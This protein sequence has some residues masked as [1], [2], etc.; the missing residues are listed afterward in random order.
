MQQIEPTAAGS[1]GELPFWRQFR[2]NLIAVFIGLALVPFLA[3]EALT[4][5]QTASEAQRQVF[6]QLESVSQLKQ[7]QIRRWLNDS[8]G[9]LN[10]LAS[11]PTGAA[12]TALAADPADE[13][14]RQQANAALRGLVDLPRGADEGNLRFQQLVFYLP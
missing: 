7:N 1:G 13:A 11:G 3:I 6:N 2:W 14:L 10:L 12:L 4:L 5:A 9:A 8:R